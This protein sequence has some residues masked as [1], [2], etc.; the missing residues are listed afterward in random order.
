MSRQEFYSEYKPRVLCKEV[1]ESLRE[2]VIKHPAFAEVFHRVL[3]HLQLGSSKQILLVI[4]A[5]G[6]GKSTLSEAVH[7]VATDWAQSQPNTQGTVWMEAPPPAGSSYSF[8][9]FYE[10]LLAELGDPIPER[11]IDPQEVRDHLAHHQ[12]RRR[13]SSTSGAQ[14]Y[15]N[16]MLK[17]FLLLGVLVDEAQH[18]GRS[19]NLQERIDA[20]DVIKS[21]TGKN[22]TKL[23][24]FGTHEAR[25]LQYLN[26]QLSRRIK[27]IHFLPYK[28]DEKGHAD[29]F[30]SFT[31]ICT[32]V[33]L[34]IT[35]GR[36][37]AGFLHKNTLGAIGLL[38]EWLQDGTQAAIENSDS[39]VTID[40]MAE[41]TPEDITLDLIRMESEE[42]ETLRSTR[43]KRIRKQIR[44]AQKQRKPGRR[45][46]TERDSAG[47]AM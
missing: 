15:V 24:F 41:T 37:H 8:R 13:I 39:T 20:M 4:G 28:M 43:H 3:T 44:K 38:S 35:V 12:G 5:S 1:L 30:A 47:G 10:Q 40:H 7:S 27:P 26:G 17:A 19:S 36:E 14:R 6:T 22:K 25:K 34:P 46:P 18:F 21:I 31:S 45:A 29:F 9:P 16:S 2:C 33:R 11:K 42:Y 23:I 32:H